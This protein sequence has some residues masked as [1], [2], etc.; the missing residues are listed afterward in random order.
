MIIFILL[1]AIA[2]C[3]CNLISAHTL[4]HQYQQFKNQ[5]PGWMI[6]QTQWYESLLG[7]AWLAVLASCCIVYLYRRRSTWL[8]RSQAPTTPTR[9]RQKPELRCVLY[10]WAASLAACIA[11]S[12]FKSIQAT[13]LP[14]PFTRTFWSEFQ[15]TGCLFYS[16]AI[17]AVVVYDRRRLHRENIEDGLCLT[18]GY[19]LRATPDICPECG[20]PIPARPSRA[21]T[22][23]N[24]DSSTRGRASSIE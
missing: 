12:A 22:T 24:S 8:G 19:D 14:Y 5:F 18:C 6:Q 16:A 11:I 7:A 3:A 17:I 20:T 2:G 13:R 4:Y 21:S 9:W 1:A 10:A 15:L 23:P